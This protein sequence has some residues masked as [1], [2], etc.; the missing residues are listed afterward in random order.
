MVK[1]YEYSLAGC[2]INMVSDIDGKELNLDRNSQYQLSTVDVA[3]GTNV[4]YDYNV[5]GQRVSRREITGSTTNTEYYIHNGVNIVAD[6][7]EDKELLRS[8]TYAPGYDNIISMTAYGDSETNT[9]F[10]IR[11]HNNSVVALVDESGDVAESYTYTAYGEVTVFD[12][13]GN[14]L[15]KSLL[16]NRYTF[17]GREIDYSTGLYNFRARWYDAET[18]HWLS[19]DPIGINGG[20][21]Q[22]VFCDNNPIM[23]IDPDGFD[24]Y[25]INRKLGGDDPRS[26]FNPLSHTFYAVKHEDGTI[27]TYGWG[28]SYDKNKNGFWK[29]HE[30]WDDSAAKPAIESG[31]AWKKGDCCLDP[32]IDEA[33]Q[34]LQNGDTSKHRWWPWSNCKTEARRLLNLARRLQ[35]QDGEGCEE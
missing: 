6:L 17:Q 7:D 9:Y 25:K 29:M 33:F 19:K 14:E 12:V 18:G 10:Y 22:Y 27:D 16:G 24:T 21:N 23:F 8:Y 26:K 30:D 34:I 32:Y 2:L 20:L 15:D 1:K 31:V 11:N 5:L 13:N 28:T 35:E 3:G 4:N